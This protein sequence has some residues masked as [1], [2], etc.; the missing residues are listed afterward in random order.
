MEVCL[1]GRQVPTHTGD[2]SIEKGVYRE[3]GLAMCVTKHATKDA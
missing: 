1:R 3:G 2:K